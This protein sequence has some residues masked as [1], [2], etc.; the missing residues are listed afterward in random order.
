MMKEFETLIIFVTIVDIIYSFIHLAKYKRTNKLDF[1]FE[2][3]RF[4]FISYIAALIAVLLIPHFSCGFDDNTGFFFYFI[5]LE[6]GSNFYP[7]KTIQ[8]QWL[9]YK[10][11]NPIG[12]LNLFVNS[13]LFAPFPVILKLNYPRLKRWYC[14][15]IPF[16]SIIIIE[17]LQFLD[18]RATDIDDVI[19]NTAGLLIGMLLL[20][21]IRKKKQCIT[22]S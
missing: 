9:L 15:L 19:L 14:F 16:A 12:I 20:P 17:S 22:S 1:K 10:I 3:F 18:G 6:F 2:F 5:K 21:I 4:V 13:I 11:G 7:F 8:E